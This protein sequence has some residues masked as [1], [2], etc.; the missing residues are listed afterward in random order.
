MRTHS[1]I[2]TSAQCL[3]TTETVADRFHACLRTRRHSFEQMSLSK[4]EMFKLIFWHTDYFK[5]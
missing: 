5:K 1:Q 2:I 4:Y 3:A